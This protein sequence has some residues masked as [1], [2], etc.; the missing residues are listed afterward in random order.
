M[1]DDFRQDSLPF[2]IA[3]V[4]KRHP[5][6]GATEHAKAI[7]DSMDCLVGGAH[8]PSRLIQGQKHIVPPEEGEL[9]HYRHSAFDY[10]DNSAE[11]VEETEMLKY[12]ELMKA[13]PLLPKLLS[14][15][16]SARTLG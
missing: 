8:A 4:T 12:V 2:E 11:S 13:H 6:I 14:P 7:V 10:L 1:S 16:K 5:Q 9:F 15:S 3:H